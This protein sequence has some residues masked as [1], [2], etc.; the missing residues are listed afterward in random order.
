MS[1]VT[2]IRN[3]TEQAILALFA[4]HKSALQGQGGFATL[5]AKA[6][7][8]FEQTG[9]PHRRI[10]AWHYTDLR[11]HSAGRGKKLAHR[12]HRCN[13]VHVGQWFL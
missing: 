6:F 12:L 1:A 5:R 11:C 8:S 7:E 9:L 3:K 2:V 10:E 4:K 13:T